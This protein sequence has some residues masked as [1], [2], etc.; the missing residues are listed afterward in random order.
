MPTAGAAPVACAGRISECLA[1]DAPLR[2]ATYELLADA[3]STR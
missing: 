1:H 2:Q 3:A